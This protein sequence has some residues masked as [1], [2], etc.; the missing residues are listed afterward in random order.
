MA[1]AQKIALPEDQSGRQVRGADEFLRTVAVGEDAVEECRALDHPGF[2]PA[3]F[4]I[5]HDERHRV[6]FPRALHAARVVIHVVG[7]ALLRHEPPSRFSTLP[8]P[9]EAEAAEVLD[10]PGVM[11]ARLA[12]VIEKLIEDA[13]G[14]VV[15]GDQRQ[16][17]GQGGGHEWQPI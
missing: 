12:R 9:V 16:L 15:V 5:A 11:P 6:Q 1:G 2:E 14:R 10:Q 3:P 8:Q 13:G 17:V 4:R 7:D